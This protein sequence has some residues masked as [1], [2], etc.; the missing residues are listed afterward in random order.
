MNMK[1]WAAA[2]AMVALTG[3]AQ[4]GLVNRGGGMIYDTV[5]N[6]TWLADMNYAQTS[7]HTGTGVNV[8]GT[9]TW[10]A[11]TAWA[12]DLVYGGF[13]DWRLPTTNTT[14]SSNCGSNFNPGGGF[15]LQYFGFNCTGS[16]MGHMFY[17]DFGAIAGSS[18]LLGSNA[19][20]LALF[21]NVQSDFY[22]SGTEYAPDPVG[23]WLFGS[24]DGFQDGAGKN[25]ALYAVAVRPGDVAASVPEPQTL[26]LALLA[27][28]ATM[29][30]RR[31]RPV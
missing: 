21:T 31:R 18:I 16:E 4:A 19:A 7:A 17:N 5:Q 1:S 11:A 9:M 22:W 14:A 24:I 28:G 12:N 3:T 26:A 6:I 13:S 2:A 10:D 15:P 29:V 25:G 23:A 27:L 20:N 8:D 30:V